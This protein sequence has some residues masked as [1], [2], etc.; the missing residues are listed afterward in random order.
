MSCFESPDATPNVSR[1]RRP[2]VGSG[3]RTFVALCPRVASRRP[4]VPTTIG[5]SWSSTRCANPRDSA[6]QRNATKGTR[7]QTFGE[8]CGPW[9]ERLRARG[10][11]LGSRHIDRLRAMLARREHGGMATF[12]RLS[13]EERARFGR[14]RTTS[15]RSSR[16]STPVAK[17]ADARLSTAAV[18][19]L[20]PQKMETLQ[21]A[22]PGAWACRLLTT[23]TPFSHSTES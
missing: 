1:E 9:Q 11:E 3:R 13:A 15:R 14:S 12:R 7:S 5:S 17:R 22:P 2:R 19:T 16:S 20:I 6:R 21:N 8:A 18:W 4:H 23:G 10:S